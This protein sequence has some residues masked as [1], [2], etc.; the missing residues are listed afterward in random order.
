MS[1]PNRYLTAVEALFRSRPGEWI[2]WTAIAAIGGALAWRT[3]ASE[4]RTILG[5]NIENRLRRVN[6]KTLSEYRYLPPAEPSQSVLS[7]G[8]KDEAA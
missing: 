4:C 3:R 7:F 1:K 8:S 5:M 6:G 2:Q